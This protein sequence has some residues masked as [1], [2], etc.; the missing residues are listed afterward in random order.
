[1]IEKDRE[2]AEVQSL[3]LKLRQYQA[4]A[5]TTSQELAFV[6]Q[7]IV[8]HEKAIETRKQLKRVKV[9]DELIVPIGANSSVYVTLSNTDKIIVGLGGGVSAEKDPGSSMEYL[10]EKK[11]NLENSLRDMSGMMQKLEQEAQKLQARLQ[12][13]ADSGTGTGRTG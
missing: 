8:E 13:I 5:E 4:Q 9:G 11:E 2:Q 1:M 6:R 7:A 10:K 12:Q 3:L